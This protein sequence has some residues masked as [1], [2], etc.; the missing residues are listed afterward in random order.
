MKIINFKKEKI[1]LSAILCIVF[2]GL[3]FSFVHATPSFEVAPAPEPTVIGTAA[4]PVT[5]FVGGNIVFTSQIS[6]VSGIASA[7]IDIKNSSGLTVETIVLF[8]DGL[9]GDGAAK[10]GTYGYEWTVPAYL[11][12]GTYKVFVVA[13]DTFGNTF[14]TAL[15]QTNFNVTASTAVLTTITV[16]PV[17][18]SIVVGGT[19]AFI[20]TAKDQFGAIFPA[21]ITWTSSAPA[22]G[23][24]IANTGLFTA[25]EAG[26][27]TVTATSGFVS[28]ST[29]VVV[30]P[31]ILTTIAIVPL[32]PTL[33]VGQTQVFVASAKDQLGNPMPATITWTSSAPL[34]G[35][36][37]SGT[38]FFTA[39]A[40]GTTTITAI[41]GTVSGSTVVTMNNAALKLTTITVTPANPT[42]TVGGTQTFTADAR[43][44][45]NNPFATAITWTSSVPAKGTIGVGSGLF[46]AVSAG[47]TT[48]KAASGAV[49]GTTLATVTNALPLTPSITSPAD[50]AEF[51]A[52]D[53]VNFNSNVVGGVAPY[54]Y[55]WKSTYSAGTPSFPA[56]MDGI[57][58]NSASFTKSDLIANKYAR[59]I[60]LTVTDNVGTT[61][62]SVVK[63]YV[64]YPNAIIQGITNGQTFIQ[65]IDSIKFDAVFC[66]SKTP[67]SYSWLS[68]IDGP[69]GNIQTFEKND[70]SIGN[71]TITLSVMDVWGQI[72]T[73]TIN[74]NVVVAAS[75]TAKISSPKIDFAPLGSPVTFTAL[76][77]GGPAPYT[78][79]WSSDKDGPIGGGAQTF[80]I[81]TLTAGVHTITLT[82]TDAAA[83]TDTKTMTFSVVSCTTLVNNG[84]PATKLDI[85]FVGSNYTA[86]QIPTFDLDVNASSNMLFSLAPFSDP[87]QKVKIN[88]HYVDYAGD[89]G[90][91]LDAGNLH[92]DAAK[93]M[94]MAAVCPNDQVGVITTLA[95]NGSALPNSG[96][97]YVSQVP[98]LVAHDIGHTFGGLEDEYD[99]GFAS[100]GNP[101]PSVPN[102][103]KAGCPKWIP[104]VVGATCDLGCSFSNWF[105]SSPDSIMRSSTALYF[106]TVSIN[107][108]LNRLSIYF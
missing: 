104:A 38:G 29:V 73:T 33:T 10:D 21:T 95:G 84:P 45:F 55:S 53:A 64:Y 1:Y 36:I 57:I 67:C 94:A 24:I 34:K 37:D 46:T 3:I 63:I 58:G 88:V 48:I 60:T 44:Q 26:T 92:C 22:K 13:S 103:D 75:L 105:R 81:N 56:D 69:I 28:G 15:E 30:S 86:A 107:R 16:T 106:N 5:Q 66:G 87:I 4:A 77:A 40:I 100:G 51:K 108:L 31:Q 39:K 47:T 97:F 102:C 41:S 65:I 54:T 19:Q 70:L 85:V 42:I 76:A 98:W 62:T 35:S 43:D 74:I 6:D 25:K 32:A 68:S 8:D 2:F 96:I 49:S 14:S 89:L 20:A 23:T 99:Y 82:V 101:L 91:Y 80:S 72:S 27:T 18:P 59:D 93:A 61:A 7:K 90:C 50:G 79:A 78:Y 11:T 83:A 9:H 17:N 52:G 71:H 12:V